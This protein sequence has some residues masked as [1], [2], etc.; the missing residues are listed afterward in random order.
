[1]VF[2]EADFRDVLDETQ[3][4]LKKHP[5]ETVVMRLKAECP[6]GGASATECANDPKSMTAEDAQSIFGHYVKRFGDLFYSPSVKGD[7]RAP[8]PSLKDVRGKLV[9][10]SFDSVGN[11]KYGIE[12]FNKNQ[13]DHWT[14]DPVQ[15]KWDHVKENV[16]RA[17]RDDKDEVY[18]AYTSA[19]KTI[20]RLPFEYAGGYWQEQGGVRTEVEGINHRLLKYLNAGDSGRVGMVMMDFPGWALV[21]TIISRNDGHIP[22]GGGNRAIWPV[23]SDRT[24]VNSQ[25]KRCMVRGP[26]FDSS[27]TGGLVTQRACRSKAPSSH[28]WQAEQPTSFEHKGYFQIKSSN[29][30]CLTVPYNDG[31][32]PPAGTQRF[33]WD[34][35]TRWFSGSQMWN[36]VPTKIGSV[37]DSKKS[38]RF[39]NNWT[40]LRLSMDPATASA[41]SGKVTQDTCPE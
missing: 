17:A 24:Y 7:K 10:G 19:S 18:V 16:D 21:D 15:K 23:N 40:N 2:Q 39:V 20:L 29:G 26:E 8:V 41:G 3:A 30:K 4:F 11:D 38:F 33:W 27:K 28:Q 14:A 37:S 6:F 31:K 1:M 32:P 36:V 12:T 9:L 22:K 13:E 25:Y 34:C 5:S 35:E